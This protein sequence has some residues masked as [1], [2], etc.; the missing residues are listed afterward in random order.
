ME[1]KENIKCKIFIVITIRISTHCKISN[2]GLWIFLLYFAPEMQVTYRY[3]EIDI[4]IRTSTFV[5]F[6]SMDVLIVIT[7][8]ILNFKCSVLITDKIRRSTLS[9]FAKCGCS[10]HY[11]ISILHL[12][13]S[14]HSNLQV[15][16]CYNDKSV[17]T[18]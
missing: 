7:I 14:L 4:P 2:C 18:L 9:Y 8:R 10:Y 5:I 16:Y 3:T 17:H 1:N 11:N 12:R 13:F 6:E 15:T